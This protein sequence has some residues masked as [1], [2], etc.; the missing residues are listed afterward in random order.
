MGYLIRDAQT[1]KIPYTIVVGE[2]EM[3]SNQVSVRK[4]GEQ[5]SES[6]SLDDFI[7]EIQEDISNYS[8]EK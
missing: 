2:S 7:K 8:R 3:N 6:L 1:N 4:Y 5:D